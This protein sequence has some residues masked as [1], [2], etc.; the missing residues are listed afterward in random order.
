MK[1]IIAMIMVM[2]VFI[3]TCAM[4]VNA[5]C[6]AEDNR[7]DIVGMEHFEAIMEITN[8]YDENDIEVPYTIEMSHAEGYWVVALYGEADE[9]YDYCAFGMYDHMPTEEEIDILWANRML[10][11]EMNNLFEQYGFY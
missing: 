9:Y 4:S 3:G 8:R 1:K 2:C 5:L 6:T 11:D 7:P 10:E